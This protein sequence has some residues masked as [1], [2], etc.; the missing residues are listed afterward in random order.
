M[1]VDEQSALSIH[2]PVVEPV[3][4]VPD[5][6]DLLRRPARPGIPA[7]VGGLDTTPS[8]VARAIED[9][10]RS[11]YRPLHSGLTAR[12]PALIPWAPSASR[13][14]AGDGDAP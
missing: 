6:A 11:G 2:R 10:K 7:L 14:D 3:T 9:L 13:R 1:H 12:E 8:S 4:N 5:G